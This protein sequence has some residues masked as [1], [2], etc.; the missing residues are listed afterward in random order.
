MI[1][2]NII[3]APSHAQIIRKT[4]EAYLKYSLKIERESL[5]N[6][7]EGIDAV[8]ITIGQEVYIC[9]SIEDLET[10]YP[11]CQFD[12]FDQSEFNYAFG[13]KPSTPPTSTST[14]DT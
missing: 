14:P 11:H 6:G 10:A 3:A 8:E 4:L 13:A 2:K 7:P 5:G 1:L 9:F 12:F